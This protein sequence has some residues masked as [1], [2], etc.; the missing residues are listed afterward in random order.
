MTTDSGN[1]NRKNL[2]RAI[3]TDIHFWIPAIVLVGGLWVLRWIR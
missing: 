1:S 3:F 2:L